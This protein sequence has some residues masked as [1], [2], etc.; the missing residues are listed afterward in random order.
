MARRASGSVSGPTSPVSSNS[1]WLKPSR[2][3]PMACMAW[4][5][6]SMEKPPA[7]KIP[8]IESM[9]RST[10]G[11]GLGRLD[12][13][14]GPG[15]AEERA[16]RR[17]HPPADGRLPVDGVGGRVDLAHD[18]VDHAVQQLVLAGHVWATT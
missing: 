17:Q 13:P 8:I 3:L 12:H 14:G 7:R 4:W 2:R 15:V 5:V 6:R 11:V 9:Y 18:H 16:P 1:S 10:V